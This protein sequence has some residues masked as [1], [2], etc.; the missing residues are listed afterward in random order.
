MADAQQKTPSPPPTTPATVPD[1]GLRQLQHYE[2]RL[3]KHRYIL[4]QKFL[5]LVRWETPYLAYIQ[6]NVRNS[7]LDNYFAITANL[8]THT[9]FMVMLPWLFWFGYTELGRA[10]VHLLAAGVFFSGFIKDYFCLPRPLS[11]PLHRITMSGSAALEYGFPSTHSTN[12]V[13]VT[14]YS[15]AILHSADAMDPVLRTSL[16]ALAWVYALSIVLG[17]LYCGMH[18]FLDVIVGSLLGALLAWVEL[19]YGDVF[20]NWLYAGEWQVPVIITVVILVFVRIHPEPA[21]S[22]PCFDDGVAFA[23]VVVGIEAGHWH[24]ARTSFSWDYPSPATVPWS[25]SEVGILKSIARIVLGVVLIFAWRGFMKPTLHTLLPPVFRIIEQTGF[26]IPRKDFKPASQYTKVPPLNDDTLPRLNE[27]PAMITSIRRPRSDSV[28]PQ[29]AADAYEAL[30]YQRRT[31]RASNEK[32]NGPRS[33]VIVG[34][35]EK[36]LRAEEEA[37]Q[38]RREEAEILMQIEKPRVRYDVEVITKLFVYSGIAWIAVEAGPVL[39]EVL[40]LGCRESRQGAAF[41]R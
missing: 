4:R 13:S 25:F 31:R 35:N 19:V 8:G 34:D 40:G 36:A 16:E 15:L 29:S 39:F 30:A 10:M 26:S 7:V 5:P 9:F 23:G 2:H 12:A 22:C 24:Y 20:N 21:D 11:P 37:E 6:K 3:P 41:D 14:V 1:A 27:L 17:R 38:D 33:Q 18:G 28:G 32:M